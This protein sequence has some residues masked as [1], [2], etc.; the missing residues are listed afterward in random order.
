MGQALFYGMQH[1]TTVVNIFK[2]GDCAKCYVYN[3]SFYWQNNYEVGGF[4]ILLPPI[5]KPR[6]GKIQ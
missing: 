2:L 3:V 5:G 4:M 6:N 1:L